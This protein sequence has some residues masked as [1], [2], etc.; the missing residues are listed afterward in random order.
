MPR[1]LTIEQ[2]KEYIENQGYMLLTDKYE[3]NRV[4]MPLECPR[5]HKFDMLYS[6]FKDRGARCPKCKKD[7]LANHKRL[8]IEEVKDI[9]ESKGYTLIQYNDAHSVE[10]QCPIGH[11]WCTSLSNFRRSDCLYCSN[12]AP[13]DFEEVKRF[14]EDNNCTLISTKYNGSKGKLKYLCS[15]GNIAET[16]W[17]TFKKGHR[18][19]ECGN[20]KTSERL[21]LSH[22]EVANIFSSNGCVLFSQYN[23]SHEKLKYMCS[24]G[25]ESDILLH[26]FVKGVRCIHCAEGMKSYGMRFERIVK[27]VFEALGYNYRYQYTGFQGLRPDFYDEVN[28]HIIDSKLSRWTVYN[29]KGD[30]SK[31]KPYCNKVSVIYLRDRNIN[32]DDGIEFI[33]I[34]SLY[35]DLINIGRAD[36]IFEIEKL[37]REI[38]GV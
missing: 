11:T 21:S 36:L 15:C 32:S 34:K 10:V 38:E 12:R 4:K 2:V 29:N 28:N 16:Y 18:C 20:K 7:V 26:N 19:K 8:A 27:E 1:K 35:P 37:E 31:Y 5:G 3:G 9:V 23:N 13:V 22:D 17:F 6:N 33:H 24:C 30:V 14:F 25:N